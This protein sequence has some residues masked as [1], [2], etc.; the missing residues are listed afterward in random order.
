MINDKRPALRLL[1]LLAFLLVSP[2]AFAVDGDRRN[3]V[4]MPGRLPQGGH[5]VFQDDDVLTC[6][7]IFGCMELG[8]LSGG[9]G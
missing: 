5:A 1:A 2:G 7:G 9:E 4:S 3:A 8:G 6:D